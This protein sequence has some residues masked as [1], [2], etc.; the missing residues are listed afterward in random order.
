MHVHCTSH[1]VQVTPNYSTCKTFR[2]VSS[3]NG[4]HLTVL[5]QQDDRSAYTEA[6]AHSHTHF[7]VVTTCRDPNVW[8]ECQVKSSVVVIVALSVGVVLIASTTTAC[9]LVMRWRRDAARTRE[10]VRRK[11]APYSQLVDA[12]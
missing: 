5:L 10:R 11:N 2:G 9:V 3:Y 7:L 4:V 6:H 8:A 12:A 1:N